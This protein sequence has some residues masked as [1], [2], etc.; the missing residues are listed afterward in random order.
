MTVYVYLH[1][2]LQICIIKYVYFYKRSLAAIG[3]FDDYVKPSFVAS[4]PECCLY[5]YC[6]L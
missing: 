5:N 2:I 4:H 3:I 1:N 6:G